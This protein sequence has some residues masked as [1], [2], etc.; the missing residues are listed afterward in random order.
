MPDAETFTAIGPLAG[1]WDE[2]ADR[3]RASPF[4][5][6]GWFT[7]WWRN[8]GAGELLVYCVRRDGRLDA[9]IPLVRRGRA[10]ASPTNLQTPEFGM[11]A[12]DRAAGDALAAAV[13]AGEPSRVSLQ[14]LDRAGVDFE[15]FRAAANAAGYRQHVRTL[16]RSPFVLLAGDWETYQQSLQKHLRDNRRRRLRRLAELGE[17]TFDAGVPRGRLDELLAEGFAVEPSG[18]KLERRT[19]VLSRPETLAFWEE[20]A[21][22]A[23]ERGWL[24]LHFLRV[25]GR[26]IAFE[27]TLV[28]AGTAWD[29]KGG[30]DPEFRRYAPGILINFEILCRLFAEGASA[31][32]M[33]GAD[34]PFKLEFSDRVHDRVLFEAF[35]RSLPGALG[36]G[37]RSYG[38]ALAKRAVLLV[39]R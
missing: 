29:M 30:Y 36:W 7:A 15:C 12:A 32:E 22:W 16:E 1:E 4:R 17:V 10:L 24:R 3:V 6:P 23:H 8:F 5:R 13:F 31:Y 9:V 39:C 37:A 2:L 14:H 11:V 26:P 21:R 19:A 20:V 38:R 34:E 28:A 33:N 18:W 25:A 35:T 27:L